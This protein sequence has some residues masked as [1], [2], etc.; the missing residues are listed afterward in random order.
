MSPTELT[1]GDKAPAFSLKNTN[2]EV[3]NLA[4]FKGKKSSSIFIPKTTR[5]VAPKKRAGFVMIILSCKNAGLKYWESAP[6]VRLHIRNS[7]KNIR[8]P[9]CC[10]LILIIR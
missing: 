6:T 4:D 1:K 7:R 8:C 3:V 10:C 2:G 9:S 5:Q